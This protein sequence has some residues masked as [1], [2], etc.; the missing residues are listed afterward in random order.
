[1]SNC[2]A[3]SDSVR[4][5]LI[6]SKATRALKAGLYFR[7]GRLV[8][9][10]PHCRHHAGLA[11]IIHSSPSSSFPKPPLFEDADAKV[12]DIVVFEETGPLAFRLHLE[13]PDGRRVR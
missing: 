8:M 6:A 2:W 11:R 1:M 9:V 3:R 13:K 4:S 5:P 12:G 7:L 10:S